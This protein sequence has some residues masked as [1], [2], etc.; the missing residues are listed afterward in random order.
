MTG[1][2]LGCIARSVNDYCRVP[3]STR[4]AESFLQRFA[5]KLRNSAWCAGAHAS[6]HGLMKDVIDGSGAIKKRI[7][8]I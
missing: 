4:R 2:L 5:G 3:A 7:W 6:N 8:R 1:S